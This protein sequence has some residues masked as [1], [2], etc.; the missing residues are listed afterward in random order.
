MSSIVST[1]PNTIQ[2]TLI[3]LPASLQYVE[4]TSVPCVAI[5]VNLQLVAALLP[6][7]RSPRTLLVSVRT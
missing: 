3:I 1:H 4:G 7:K 5:V 6:N 2:S